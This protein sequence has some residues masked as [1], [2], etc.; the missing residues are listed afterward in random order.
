M[1]I[2]IN[3]KEILNLSTECLKAFAHQM[4]SSQV[5]SFIESILVSALKNRHNAA[6]KRMKEDCRPLLI[7]AG[8][9]NIPLDNDQCIGLIASLEGYKDADA[10][11]ADAE[12]LGV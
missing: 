4:P 7:A 2:Y 9:V 11:N 1:K 5:E 10:R 3:D 12:A 6:V 8:H